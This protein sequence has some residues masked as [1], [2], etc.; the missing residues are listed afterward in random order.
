MGYEIRTLATLAT[1]AWQFLTQSIPG[2]IVRIWPNTFRVIGK[3]LALLDFEHELRRQWLFQQLFASTAEELWLTRHGFELGLTPDPGTA[4]TGLVTVAATPGLL[5]PAGLSFERADGSTY[6]TLVDA[7]AAGAT[8][9]LVVMAD[10]TGSDY[11]VEAGDSLSLVTTIA[12]PFGL[13]TTGTV[14]AAGIGGGVDP[15]ELEA[16][17]ARV[18]FR[19]RNPPQGGSSADYVEWAG[20][21]LASVKAVY[22]DSFS[23]DS[24]SVWVCFTVSDQPNGLPTDDEV[25]T[26]QAYVND[27]I[28]R[29]VTARVFATGPT[30]VAVPIALKNF[31]PDTPD[32]RAAVAAEIAALQVDEIQPATPS[33]AFVL[34]VEAIEAAINRATGVQA[35]TLVS[36]AAD[37]T[38][39]TGGQMPVLGIPSY[40]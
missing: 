1:Q 15:E 40:S 14:G 28:R 30:P 29:P 36:P 5:V 18:L 22:V 23:N 13:G 25:A 16:F 8:V 37:E 17:R 35:F 2:A 9:D 12:A 6:T 3:V 7:T 33:T 20:E 11:D 21:A 19:K 4:S 10:L 38:Y 26:V 39:S 27:P 31:A 24:R 32:T 34:Y